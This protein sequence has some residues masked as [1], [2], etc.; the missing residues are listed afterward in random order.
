M[1]ENG[2]KWRKT[3]RNNYTGSVYDWKW[4]DGF[5]LAGNDRTCLQISEYSWKLDGVGPVDN[6]PS[7]D[8]FHHYVQKK[9]KKK[10]NDMWHVT[11]DMFVGGVNILSNF[12]LPSSYRLW[13]M[14]LW[15]SGGKGWLN[16]WINELMN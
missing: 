15:R 10:K 6:R 14:I 4:L 16:E 2:W 11:R 12:Q 5:E 9:R 1:A 3:A 13:F 8:K 7:T